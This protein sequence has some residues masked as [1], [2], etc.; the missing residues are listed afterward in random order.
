VTFK[1]SFVA[2]EHAR[3]LEALA[4]VGKSHIQP[5]DFVVAAFEGLDSAVSNFV[6]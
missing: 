6:R 3:A 1:L 2:T 5:L 4:R